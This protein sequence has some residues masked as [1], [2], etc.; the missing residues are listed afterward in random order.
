MP[1]PA[2]QEALPTV[3]DL[4]VQVS[5]KG[6]DLSWS[7]PEKLKSSTEQGQYH[8][9]IVKSE[10]KWDKRNCLE[11]PPP[12]QE[13]VQ[14]IDLAYP[15][16]ATLQD[17]KV[18]WQDANVALRHAYRYQVAVADKKGRQIS[19]SNPVLVSIYTPPAGVKNLTATTE[20]KGILLKWRAPTTDERG[21]PLQ[22]EVQYLVERH[23]AG[24]KWDRM[25]NALMKGDSYLDQS[26]A[27]E[28]AYD[29]RVTPLVLVDGTTLIG[30]AA[31]I[32]EAKS[33]EALPPPP[34]GRVWIIPSNDGMEVQ[35]TESQ[36]KVEGYHV[37]R[38]EGKEII[39]LTS[40]PVQRPPFIDRAMKKNTVYFY[41]V[42][43]VSSQPDHKEGL[44]SKWVEIRSLMSE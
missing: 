44:L 13:E 3:R 29:Y 7:I 30:E 20:Q 2:S 11:C 32:R 22:G 31:F 27:S 6:A 41:A 43:A 16:T 8:F 17:N 35:W 5:S 18:L 39:R 9:S 40:S 4:K 37:Y 1:R 15:G 21:Q 25:S 28:Q 23:G 26:L 10:V 12:S 24:G 14:A 36:G 38:R 33:P 42:S 34:P 19:S